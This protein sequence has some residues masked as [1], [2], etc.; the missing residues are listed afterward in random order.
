MRSWV[1][2]SH[3]NSPLSHNKQP[4]TV[5]AYSRSGN[6]PRSK[7]GSLF[8]TSHRSDGAALLFIQNSHSRR[9]FSQRRQTSKR[10]HK[11][12]TS[13][14]NF[15]T[16]MVLRPFASLEKKRPQRTYRWSLGRSWIGST[17]GSAT[18]S[19]IALGTAVAKLARR[20]EIPP[21]HYR[22]GAEFLAFEVLHIPISPVSLRFHLR[23]GA[24]AVGHFEQCLA[25][26]R[27]VPHGFG[28]AGATTFGIRGREPLPMGCEFGRF[29]RGSAS[30]IMVLGQFLKF[31]SIDA[32]HGVAGSHH[33]FEFRVELFGRLAVFGFECR[34]KPR[35]RRHNPKSR[36]GGSAGKPQSSTRRSSGGGR[37]WSTCIKRWNVATLSPKRRGDTA[38][39]TSTQ[40]EESAGRLP[41]WIKIPSR[42]GTCI[43]R[44]SRAPQAADHRRGERAN[45]GETTSRR[46]AY[47]PAGMAGCA[48]E[49]GGSRVAMGDCPLSAGKNSTPSVPPGRWAE[50]RKRIN[51]DIRKKFDV[52]NEKRAPLAAPVANVEGEPS[53]APAAQPPTSRH[54][55]SVEGSR[56]AHAD[57]ETRHRASSRRRCRTISP[58]RGVGSRGATVGRPS[59]HCASP[60]RHSGPRSSPPDRAPPRAHLPQPRAPAV[61]E[62]ADRGAPR[63]P[64][65]RRKAQ[66]AQCKAPPH[67]RNEQPYE[68]SRPPHERNEQPHERSGPS[69]WRRAHLPEAW[70]PRSVRRLRRTQITGDAEHAARIDQAL[71][72]DPQHAVVNRA[73]GRKEKP[74]QSEH[75]AGGE[76][77]YGGVFLQF[78]VCHEQKL[79]EKH[80]AGA[81]LRATAHGKKEDGLNKSADKKGYPFVTMCFIE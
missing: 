20:Q 63:T 46:R 41:G 68:R 74:Q 2:T 23:V 5:A 7:A 53:E 81:P 31:N 76:Q 39:P 65:V 40:P 54:G 56:G 3:G 24:F 26:V 28:L 21:L 80:R 30:R 77:R 22:L 50:R 57:G 14:F 17:T 16:S 64:A 8:L 78:V 79:R 43:R 11:R 75:H 59:A 70:A 34:R 42:P 33:L 37:R 58:W 12:F 15:G 35:E 69:A 47:S 45:R 10:A 55:G 19:R 61:R 67:E 29:G 72:E 49:A 48:P 52:V 6:P 66:A 25:E 71:G 44:G 9:L 27:C 60:G 38:R 18:T 4:A 1:S 51:V 13:S 36:R 32:A 73:H 62:R